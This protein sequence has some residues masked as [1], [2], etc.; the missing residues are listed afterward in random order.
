MKKTLFVFSIAFILN[1]IWENLHS[2]LYD[3]YMGGEITQFIL[4]RATL[5]DA[6]MITLVAL[7]FLFFSSLKKQSW[8]MIPALFLISIF[9]EYYALKTGRWAYNS[10]MPLVPFLSVGLSPAIQ[11]GLLGYISFKTEERVLQ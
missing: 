4:L 6:I 1:L 10:L 3:N 9:I 2:L 7:P 5:A 11:L 8:V